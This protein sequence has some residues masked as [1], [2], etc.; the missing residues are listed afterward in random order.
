MS[1]PLT[2]N[3]LYQLNHLMLIERSIDVNLIAYVDLIVYNKSGVFITKSWLRTSKMLKIEKLL[4]ISKFCGHFK[5]SR[6]YMRIGR[7]AKM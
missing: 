4:K 5:Y 3:M 6:A 7:Y 2:R 1:E